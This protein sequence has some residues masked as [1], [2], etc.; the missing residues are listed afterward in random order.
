MSEQQKTRIIPITEFVSK[1]HLIQFTDSAMNMNAGLD[2]FHVFT[3]HFT[4][5]RVQNF[6][7]N[8]L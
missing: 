1:I 2:R 8:A 6:K 3:K 7:I 5:A 4:C